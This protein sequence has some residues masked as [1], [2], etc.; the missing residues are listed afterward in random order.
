MPPYLVENSGASQAGFEVSSSPG[1]FLTGSG[2]KGVFGW[3]PAKGGFWKGSDQRGFLAESGR[4]DL[5]RDLASGD[6][7]RNPAG[8]I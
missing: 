2:P 3:D 5:G 6:F 7:W 1:I 4:G 8:G